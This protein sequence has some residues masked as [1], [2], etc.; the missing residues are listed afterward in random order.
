[1]KEEKKNFFLNKKYKYKFIRVYL[2]KET[3]FVDGSQFL[4]R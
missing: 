2:K 3:I 1:M 4:Q